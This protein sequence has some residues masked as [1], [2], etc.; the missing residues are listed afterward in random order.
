M[1]PKSQPSEE[2]FGGL[3][4]EGDPAAAQ[5]GGGPNIKAPAYDPK[6][7]TMKDYKRRV[8]VFRIRT[9]LPVEK[10]AAELYAELQGDAWVHAEDLDPMTLQNAGGV[11][12]LLDF[13]ADKFDDEKAMELGSELKAFFTKMRRESGE[14]IRNYINRFDSQVSRLKTLQIEFPDQALAWPFMRRLGLPPDR[15]AGVLNAKQNKYELKPLQKQT[16]L[17]VKDARALD[18]FN[19]QRPVPAQPATAKGGARQRRWGAHLTENHEE[20][21]NFEAFETQVEDDDLPEELLEEEDEAEAEVFK[22]EKMLA[23]AKDRQK[24]AKQARGFYHRDRLPGHKGGGRGPSSPSAGGKGGSERIKKLKARTHCAV[25]QKIGHW[26]GDPECPGPPKKAHM[27]TTDD[28]HSLEDDQAAEQ[29]YTSWHDKEQQIATQSFFINSV[30][31]TDAVNVIMATKEELLQQCGGKLLPDSRCA[32]SVGGQVWYDDI[33]K[34]LAKLGLKPIEFNEREA[35]RF[36]AGKPIM[37]TIGALFPLAVRGRHF[38]LR[39]S[40]V[41]CLAPALLSQKALGQLGAVHDHE[42]EAGESTMTFRKLGVSDLELGQTKS[43]HPSFNVLEFDRAHLFTLGNVYVGL[44]RSARH[45][46]FSIESD[47]NYYAINFSIES[48]PN[49]NTI[50]FKESDPN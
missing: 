28:N 9:R 31:M 24:D 15:E 6:S 36:G 39:I 46:D 41:P 18:K 48:D 4:E 25:C 35:F 11:Q 16:L 30:K 32:K 49:H 1:A 43:G 3:G 19:P 23:R 7:M 50:N 45:F 10:Q 38:T 29:F 27:T 12:M 8:A 14:E 34:K 42:V 22:L 33:K 5:P 2:E 47:P 37:S 21:G 20:D 13:L 26:K 17:N 44:Q 40:I